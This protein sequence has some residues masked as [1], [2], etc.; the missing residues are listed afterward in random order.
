MVKYLA[1]VLPT[2]AFGTF[3]RF[4]NNSRNSAFL[5]SMRNFQNDAFSKV[6][7]VFWNVVFTIYN[8]S[9][10]HIFWYFYRVIFPAGILR[11]KIAIAVSMSVLVRC[12]K[13]MPMTSVCTLCTLPLIFTKCAQCAPVCTRD[14]LL[15]DGLCSRVSASIGAVHACVRQCHAH[16]CTSLAGSSP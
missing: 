15:A 8:I 11:L 6:Y 3:Q 14:P 4:R 9:R 5:K 2:G 12:P 10:K 16:V 7:T 1:L 13:L